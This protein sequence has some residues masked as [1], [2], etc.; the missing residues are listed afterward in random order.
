MGWQ[1]GFRCWVDLL[2]GHL[3]RWPLTQII[4]EVQVVLDLS[5]D[6]WFWLD[7]RCWTC[8]W[9]QSWSSS[10]WAKG[11]QTCYMIANTKPF[12]ASI[13]I[14]LQRPTSYSVGTRPFGEA[15]SRR[16]HLGHRPRL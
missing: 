10:S 6:I 5:K 7:L 12:H 13:H 1:A 15:G 16:D 11:M 2:R 9:F 3:R 8:G 14:G 4:T